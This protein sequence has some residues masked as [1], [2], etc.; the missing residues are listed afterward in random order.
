MTIDDMIAE[1]DA[2]LVPLG[3]QIEGFRDFERMLDKPDEAP[4]KAAV[5]EAINRYEQRRTR[6]VAARD[7]LQVLREDEYPA[8]LQTN[9][10]PEVVAV[11]QSNKDSVETAF[12]QVIPPGTPDEAQQRLEAATAKLQASTAD[13]RA[14]VDAATPNLF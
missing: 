13:T 1:L 6:I 12:D 10:P 9:F 14:A 11:L 5:H 4:A 3:E 2:A 7:Q 8:V